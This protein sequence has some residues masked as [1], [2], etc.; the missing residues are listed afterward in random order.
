[1]DCSEL[2]PSKCANIIQCISNLPLALLSLTTSPFLSSTTSDGSLC[3]LVLKNNILHASHIVLRLPHIRQPSSPGPFLL[4]LNNFNTVNVRTV[5]LV[6]HLHTYSCQFI[7]EQYR[8]INPSST[9]IDTD[10][11]KGITGLQSYE[12]DITDF[13]TL[14]I[15]LCE[16]LCSSPS[17]IK[18]RYLF[19]VN[20]L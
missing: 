20:G 16:K 17:R 7:P 18:S 10:S 5:D 3:A 2:T 12:E 13:S 11:S 1:M 6:P 19:L 14:R 4:S 15:G 9:D 8:R